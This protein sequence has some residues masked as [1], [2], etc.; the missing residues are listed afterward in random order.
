VASGEAP[1]DA[2]KIDNLSVG[3]GRPSADGRV[4]G[5]VPDLKSRC[6]E[7]F[8]CLPRQSRGITYVN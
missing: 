4:R 5:L 3:R 8:Y 1:F 6:C 2:R 7:T